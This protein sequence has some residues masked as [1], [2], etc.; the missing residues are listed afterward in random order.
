[1]SAEMGFF[2]LGGGRGS[3]RRFFQNE[4][5]N[6]NI[7]KFWCVWQAMHKTL[8]VGNCGRA[9]ETLRPAV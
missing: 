3:P 5:N 4:A 9:R 1:M 6:V 2:F 8:S 7:N